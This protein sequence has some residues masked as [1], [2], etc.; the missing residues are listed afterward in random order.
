MPK[1]PEARSASVA[2]NWK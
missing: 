2:S 1:N